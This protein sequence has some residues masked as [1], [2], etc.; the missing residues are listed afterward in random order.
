M[1]A[2]FLR[3]GKT[4]S[5]FWLHVNHPTNKAR[6]HIEE[7]CHWVRQA[8]QRKS[9]GMSYGA[10]RGDENGYWKG[11]FSNLQAAQRAQMATGK[12]LKDQCKL[13]FRSFS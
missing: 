2:K 12:N 9:Q 7:G 13:C 6:I 10:V 5:S 11:P 3:R 1:L 4:A 8:V